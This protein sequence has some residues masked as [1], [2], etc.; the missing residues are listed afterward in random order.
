M[1]G[2]QYQRDGNVYPAVSL[3]SMSS[4]SVTVVPCIGSHL[5]TGRGA[6]SKGLRWAATVAR[7]DR[8]GID[9]DGEVL[10]HEQRV[11]PPLRELRVRGGDAA[12]RG[13]RGR[14]RRHRQRRPAAEAVEQRE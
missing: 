6:A 7:R 5:R 4:T 11:P 2:S 10:A 14:R 3:A 13:D 9:G 8:P 12:E 1:A